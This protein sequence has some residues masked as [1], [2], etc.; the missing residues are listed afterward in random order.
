M[1][2]ANARL[3]AAGHVVDEREAAVAEARRDEQNAYVE[4]TRLSDESMALSEE[5]ERRKSQADG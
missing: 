2:L 5:L 3:A 1:D 4:L